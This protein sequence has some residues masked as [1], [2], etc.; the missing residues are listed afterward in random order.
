M[1]VF[2]TENR[3]TRSYWSAKP[4]TT[5][6]ICVDDGTEDGGPVLAEFRDHDTA[7]RACEGIGWVVTDTG[8]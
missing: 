3:H 8:K 5:W 4:V 6:L 7:V 2:I 1:R